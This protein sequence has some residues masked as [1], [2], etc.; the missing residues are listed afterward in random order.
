MFCSAR[1]GEVSEAGEN[2]GVNRATAVF[3]C[4]TCDYNYCSICSYRNGDCAD[5]EA[6][7]VRCDNLMKRISQQEAPAHPPSSGSSA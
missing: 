6:V 2:P 3:Y 5:D 7:C 1:A 4:A